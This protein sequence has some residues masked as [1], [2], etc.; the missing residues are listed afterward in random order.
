MLVLDNNEDRSIQISSEG[1]KTADVHFS[2]GTIDFDNAVQSFQAKVHIG[3]LSSFAHFGGGIF[4]M[5][6]VKR[7]R[8]TD[9]FLEM[10]IAQRKCQ[11]ELYEDCSTRKLVRECNCIPSEMPG[12]QVYI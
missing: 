4:T 11:A 9:A 12:F 8:S 2:K 3:T 6:D 1:E 5:T 10:P 7:M